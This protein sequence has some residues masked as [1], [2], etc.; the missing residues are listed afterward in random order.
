VKV[1]NIVIV[2]VF[3]L[4]VTIE[5]SAL[6][7]RY[8]G[9][10]IGSV[11]LG[12]SF[13]NAIL[14]LNRFLGFLI[15]PLIGFRVDTGAAPRELLEL[16]ACG[17]LF[18]AVGTSLVYLYWGMISESFCQVLQKIKTDGYKLHSF[19]AISFEKGRGI[20]P[21]KGRLIPSFFYSSAITTGLFVSVSFVLNLIAI[22]HFNYRGSI[23]Q[24]TGAVSGIGSLLLN[25]YTNPHLA[26]A[27][28]A[29]YA[30]DGYH[31]VFAGKIFG[32]AVISPLLV[33]IVWGV[34]R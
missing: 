34:F 10:K 19:S 22:Y 3:F 12:Y 33:L 4:F 27:E 13:H 1:L 7:A 14:S 28:E 2:V 26:V 9:W 29:G 5:S 25:F 16:T 11:S 18:A 8:A 20:S 24:L 21:L 23:L 15:G 31:S 32:V 17:L 30:N 6:I